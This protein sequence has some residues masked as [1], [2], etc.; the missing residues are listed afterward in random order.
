MIQEF[1]SVKRDV[2]AGS[3]EKMKDLYR[4]VER[5]WMTSTVW[6]PRDISAYQ[7]V[8]RTREFLTNTEI[9]YTF[10]NL[11]KRPKLIYHS[12]NFLNFNLTVY[13][14]LNRNPCI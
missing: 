5:T 12:F 11:Q 14:E 10:K 8:V 4:Y 3:N 9:H 7:R 6:K 1:S 2:D 13:F